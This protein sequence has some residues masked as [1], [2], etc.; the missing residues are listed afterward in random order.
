MSEARR[1][2]LDPQAA[3]NSISDR[4]YFGAEGAAQLHAMDGMVVGDPEHFDL[5]TRVA[6][7]SCYRI[8]SVRTEP[9]NMVERRLD[10]TNPVTIRFT[11][12]REGTMIIRQRGRKQVLRAGDAVIG[13]DEISA[14]VEYPERVRFVSVTVDS[15]IPFPG[16]LPEDRTMRYI[17]RDEMF[18]GAAASFFEALLR[19]VAFPLAPVDELRVS[20]AIAKVINE[21]LVATT[22]NRESAAARR[23]EERTV[24]RGYIAAHFTRPD[25]SVAAIA[26]HYGM[27]AR[28]LQR[29]YSDHGENVSNVI[30]QR[31]LEH[32]VS[33]L[34]DARFDGLSIDDISVR[35]GFAGA[36][37]LRRV[38]GQV[39]EQTPT[40]LRARRAE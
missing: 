18:N 11:F 24:V 7:I 40:Q 9:L 26:E 23:V 8:Q 30:R 17:P 19:P 6:R 3:D 25:L 1:R 35:S 16:G 14:D 34:L 2:L 10:P 28:S 37:Q 39:M 31:R 12:L 20:R 38:M 32:A 13:F 36:N 4:A 27:S 33:M 29:L 22:P 21:V 5:R 15:M